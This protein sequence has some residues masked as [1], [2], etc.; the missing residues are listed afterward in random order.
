MIAPFLL[1][2]V[3]PTGNLRTRKQGGFALVTSLL[4]LIIMTLLALSMF[5]SLGLQEKIAGN[6]REKQR[7]LQAAESALQYGEWWLSQGNGGTGTTCT[8]VYSANTVANMQTCTNALANPTTLPWTARGDY[9]PPSMTV[10]SGGGLVSTGV[11][12]GDINYYAKPS[13][14]I[15]YLGLDPTGKTQLYQV[16]G[17]GYGGSANSVSVVRSTYAVTYKNPP[18]DQP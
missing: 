17:A 3:L 18:L 12:A 11:T 2:R 5:R 9:L 13:L 6:T 1:S 14:Y 7:S 8:T 15:Q 10:A 4:V 16:T